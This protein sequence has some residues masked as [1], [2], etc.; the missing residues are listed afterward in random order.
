MTKYGSGNAIEHMVGD[1]VVR[2]DAGERPKLWLSDF[3][4]HGITYAYDPENEETYARVGFNLPEDTRVFAEIEDGTYGQL[5]AIRIYIP[6]ANPWQEAA[7]EVVAT[8]RENEAFETARRQP[9]PEGVSHPGIEAE[10][11]LLPE[12][13][14]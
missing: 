9:D 6:G 4:T 3:G 2:F 5:Q 10:D 12:F 11:D 7:D 1:L 13:L 14:G 8:A